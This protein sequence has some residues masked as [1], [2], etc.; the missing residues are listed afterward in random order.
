[1]RGKP[2]EIPADT[3]M[4]FRVQDPLTITEHLR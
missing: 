3:R 4:V 2:V 1:V